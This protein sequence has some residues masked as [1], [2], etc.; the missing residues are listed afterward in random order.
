MVGQTNNNNNYKVDTT[1]SVAKNAR[2]NRAYIVLN[3]ILPGEA[4]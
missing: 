3:R 4:G 1:V 2:D